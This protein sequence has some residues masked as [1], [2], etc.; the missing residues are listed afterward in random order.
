MATSVWRPLRRYWAGYG[1]AMGVYVPAVL[2]AGWLVQHARPTGLSL[3][4]LAVVPAVPVLAVIGLLA[5]Y[6][7][8]ERDEF[9]RMQM[10][11]TLLGG[12]A[13]VLAITTVWGFLQLLAGAPGLATYLVFP[14]FCLGM[15]GSGPFIAWRYR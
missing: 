5:R 3:Y 1:L 15:F 7:I 6:L 4:A 13:F 12:I 9:R 11:L 10:V 2:A 8:E 14:L